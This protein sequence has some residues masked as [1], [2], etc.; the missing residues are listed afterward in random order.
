MEF[1]RTGKHNNLIFN[2]IV[3][4]LDKIFLPLHFKP[5]KAMNILHKVTSTEK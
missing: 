2:K 5:N 4:A 1:F 3:P